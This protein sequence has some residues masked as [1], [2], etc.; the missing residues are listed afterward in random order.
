MRKQYIFVCLVLL[1]FKAIAG[2]LKVEKS[3]IFHLTEVVHID[4]IKHFCES[5]NSNSAFNGVTAITAFLANDLSSGLSLQPQ[6]SGYDQIS[7]LPIDHE[8][9]L[10]IGLLTGLLLIYLVLSVLSKIKPYILCSF[11]FMSILM[12]YIWRSGYAFVLIPSLDGSPYHS[13][14]FFILQSIP[15]VVYLIITKAVTVLQTR[16]YQIF[17]KIFTIF[18]RLSIGYL[19]LV[20]IASLWQVDLIVKHFKVVQGIFWVFLGLLG[21][22]S[23]AWLILSSRKNLNFF[24]FQ[25]SFGL[26]FLISLIG[27]FL[28]SPSDFPSA[29]LKPKHLLFGITIQLIYMFWLL[30]TE[31]FENQNSD[32]NDDSELVLPPAKRIIVDKHN[33]SLDNLSPREYDIFAAYCNGFSYSEISSSFLISPNT[34]KS[35]LKSCYRKLEIN[36]KVEAISIMN[37]KKS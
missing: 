11:W 1:S 9:I 12:L 17:Q 32:E 16:D 37:N 10:L 35:H 33:S 7:H 36:S 2:G 8:E 19:A 30:L 3:G 4:V 21:I 23:L 18:L 20:T 34:V 15:L 31:V 22:P 29:F 26:L 25:T 14:Y 5:V 13:I 24:K 6:G 27:K 28:L